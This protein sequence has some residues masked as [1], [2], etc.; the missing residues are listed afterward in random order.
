M[1]TQKPSPMSVYLRNQDAG[2]GCSA[3]VP[4]SSRCKCPQRRDLERSL[5]RLSGRVRFRVGG[6]ERPPLFRG[7]SRPLT[8]PP[9]SSAPSSAQICAP[10][11]ACAPTWGGGFGEVA[12]VLFIRFAEGPADAGGRRP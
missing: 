11:S 2:G 7:L 3:L 4:H 6:R 8:P 9:P 10:S 1:L 5:T 12:P